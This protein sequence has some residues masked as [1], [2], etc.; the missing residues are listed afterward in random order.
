M[1]KMIPV[2]PRQGSNSS[3]QAVFS[4]LEGIPDRPDWVVIHSLQLTDNLVTIAGECD[5]V[6][7]VPHKGI[8]VIETKSPKYAVYKNGDWYL[9]KTPKPDKSPLDQLNKASAS[10]HRFLDNRDLFQDIPIARLVW[11]TSLSRFQFD[12]QSPGDMQL[13]EWELAL[14]EDINKPASVIEKVLDEYIATHKSRSQL[15]LA[16][17]LFT[18]AAVDAAAAALISDF[19]L[20]QTPED[21]AIERSGHARRAL[22]EQVAILDVIETNEH[23]YLDGAAGTGKSFMLIEAAR[24]AARRGRRCLVVCWNVMMAEE[25]RREIGPRANISVYD[26]NT[27]M[28]EVCGLQSN[29]RNADTTWFEAVLPARALEVLEKKPQWGDFESIF[30]DEFQDIAGNTVLFELIFKLSASKKSS[31]TQLVL[32]GDKNQQ[33]VS[34]KGR[35]KNPFDIAK[36]LISDL[37]HVRLRTNCRAIPKL[38]EKVPGLTGLDVDIVRHRLPASSEGGLEVVRVSEGKESKALA[39]ILRS[40]TAEFRAKEIRVLSPF[41]AKSSLIGELFSRE[42][43][44]TDERWLKK[45]LRDPNGPDGEI[46]WRS[47]AKFKGLE[48]DVIVITDI[49]KKASE[50]ASETG[51]S[52][53]ELLYVGVTRARYRCVVLAS[54]EVLKGWHQAS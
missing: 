29:P 21:R 33:I 48:S 9:D 14:R 50:F 41:G 54:D 36:F 4:A 15:S 17:D 32:A 25:L 46:P 11:F 6:V 47:I 10:I 8:L 13:Y 24:N 53:S 12:N 42:S 39:E 38:A 22:A 31:G 27:L 1:A 26:F 5:F 28:L 3:E 23:I 19:K 37:V 51:K 2:E 40:L 52:L 43:K 49:N 18:K 30:V 44:S 34:S 16:P 35:S 20:Y 7:L 45:V